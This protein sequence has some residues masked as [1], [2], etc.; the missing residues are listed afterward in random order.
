[1]KAFDFNK[2]DAKLNKQKI[3]DEKRKQQESKILKFYKDSP[4]NPEVIKFVNTI[5]NQYKDH[6]NG[7]RYY[8][9]SQDNVTA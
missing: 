9:I 8:S 7:N 4:I 1:M 2:L 5:H 6:Y 3:L